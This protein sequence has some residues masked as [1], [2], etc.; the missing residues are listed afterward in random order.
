MK[1]VYKYFLV[2]IL[3][4]F[5]IAALLLGTTAALYHGVGGNLSRRSMAFN[6]KMAIAEVGKSLDMYYSDCGSYPPEDLGLDALIEDPNDSILCENWGPDPYFVPQ[7]KIRW[8][9]AYD[10]YYALEAAILNKSIPGNE[11][12]EFFLGCID[13]GEDP[14]PLP[15]DAFGRP[16]KYTVTE[17]RLE[18]E[19]ISFGEDG[20][21]GGTRW[22]SDLS[23]NDL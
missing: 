3:A 7:S 20:V 13:F 12:M 10:D 17:D 9:C 23:S 5:G 21:E 8:I 2:L 19:L 11:A 18:Y 22:D 4:I 1:K 6:N 16:F 14:P 15:H